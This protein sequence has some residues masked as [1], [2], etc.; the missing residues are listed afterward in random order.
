VNEE[1]E[2]IGKPSLLEL[3]NEG[4]VSI[5]EEAGHKPYRAAQIKNWVFRRYAT[6]FEEMT[7][8]PASLRD[9]LAR[10]VGFRRLKLMSKQEGGGDWA[11][12]YVWGT[13]G[14]PLVESVLLKYRY[15][16]TGCVSTQVGCPVGCVFCASRH[17]GYERG[18]TDAEIV[19]EFV[20]MCADQKIRIGRLVF[21]GTGEPFLNY[22]NVMAAIDTLC[23][24]GAYDLSRRKITVSTVGIPEAMRAFARDSKGVRLAL[25]LHAAS[26][27][28]RN[29]LIPLNRTYPVHEVVSALWDYSEETGQ[30]V[31]VEYMLLSG[32]NDQKG[33]AKA[34]AALVK[35]IDCLVNLIPWNPVPGLPWSRPSI[36]DMRAFKEVLERNRVKVTLRRS[37]G[38]TIEAACGQL[39][40]KMLDR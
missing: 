31:T 25:S 22:R 28:L 4:L 23:D 26:D 24:P 21:M 32:L 3:S 15:G 10:R 13:K 40:R 5:I 36:E 29:S 34:L 9:Y 14:T 20:G 2:D 33:D 12:R 19:E 6:S 11:K 38:G 18:L 35:G 37:L 30:R 7:D 27:E 8:L 17:L 39:R 1:L 16:L